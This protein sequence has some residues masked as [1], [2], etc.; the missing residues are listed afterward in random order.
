M[1]MDIYIY[2]KRY[3]FIFLVLLFGLEM[4]HHK[5]NIDSYRFVLI[6][7]DSYQSKFF[8]NQ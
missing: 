6:R 8:F 5:K 4:F 3:I 2:I 1:L 7:I